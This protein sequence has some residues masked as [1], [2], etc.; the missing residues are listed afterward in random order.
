MYLI[1]SK[2]RTAPYQLC[3][4]ENRCVLLLRKHKRNDCTAKVQNKLELEKETRRNLKYFS[5]KFGAY[6]NISY[7]CN[8]KRLPLAFRVESRVRVR[9]YRYCPFIIAKVIIGYA[10]ECGEQDFIGTT[11][12]FFA[13]GTF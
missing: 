1:I 5:K 6:S 8:V 12:F 10:A 4:L 11:P 13:K 3:P 7:I 2:I 9:L